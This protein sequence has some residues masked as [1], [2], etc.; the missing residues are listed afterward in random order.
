MKNV[1]KLTAV[2]VVVC[3]VCSAGAALAHGRKSPRP[4]FRPEF[5]GEPHNFEM[6]Q[7]PPMP[8]NDFDCRG[9]RMGMRG[10][11]GRFEHGFFEKNMPEE[12]K[13]KV[14]EAEKLK[15]DLRMLLSAPKV[16]KAKALDTF[17]S[18]QKIK[19]VLGDS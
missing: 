18:I 12:I 9:H 19:S 16:D 14:A 7:R 10:H 13:A 11:H 15:I 4:D 8:H 17:Q 5:M 1:K 2:L 6:Q 3:V